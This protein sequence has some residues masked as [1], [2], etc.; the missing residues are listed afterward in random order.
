MRWRDFVS[1]FNMGIFFAGYEVC[2]Y[3]ASPCIEEGFPCFFFDGYYYWC[4][5]LF[6][7]V[8]KFCRYMRKALMVWVRMDPA[9]SRE[10]V[11]IF[12]W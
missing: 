1:S 11:V 12:W 6:F 8:E 3:D 9:Y 5:Y 10:V 4:Y 7:V 2:R